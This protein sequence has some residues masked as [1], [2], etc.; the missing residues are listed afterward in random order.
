MSLIH[1]ARSGQ[2]LSVTLWW[3]QYA[4]SQ[5]RPRAATN[6]NPVRGVRK[7][8]VGLIAF[9]AMA[10]ACSGGSSTP[11]AASTA[12]SSSVASSSG[13]V[14]RLSCPNGISKFQV[15]AAPVGSTLPTAA[16]AD[17]LAA[18]LATDGN[19]KSAVLVG[20][21]PQ[22]TRYA[23]IA[24][25]GAVDQEVIVTDSGGTAFHEVESDTCA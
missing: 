17:E 21:D 22:G 10:T 16:T 7:M 18:K 3:D 19:E 24:A 13:G 14:P 23:L 25:D 4:P 9:G 15:V 6:T 2:R 8:A 20:P 12:A 1:A 5:E 11:K